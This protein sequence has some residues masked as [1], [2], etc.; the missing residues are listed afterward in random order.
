[1]SKI[2]YG[3]EMYQGGMEDAENSGMEDEPDAAAVIA[4][5]KAT[6]RDNLYAAA[7][8]FDLLVVESLWV[9]HVDD[10]GKRTSATW[11]R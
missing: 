5:L 2:Q 8:D 9:T 4:A 11:S 10:A 3:V 1:M 6:Y 7:A